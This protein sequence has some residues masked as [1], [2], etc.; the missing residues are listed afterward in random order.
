MSD[1]YI[2]EQFF[3]LLTAL[4]IVMILLWGGAEIKNEFTIKK[5]FILPKAEWNCFEHTNG[6]CTAYNY[7]GE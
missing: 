1:D 4:A 2:K 7:K 5:N 3:M 6:Q